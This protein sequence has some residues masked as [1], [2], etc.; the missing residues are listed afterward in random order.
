MADQFASEGD[1]R[2]AM[3]AV[4]LAGLRYLGEKGL[5]TLQPAKTGMEYGRELARRLRDVPA[6][7]DGFGSG[8]RQYEG[9]WYGFGTASAEPYQ[10]LRGTWEEMRRHA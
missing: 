10:T 5:V 9:V 8:L 4:H 7:M 6:A 3:R 2:L 1:F